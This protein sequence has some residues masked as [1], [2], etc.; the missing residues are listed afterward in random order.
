MSEYAAEVIIIAILAV[1]VVIYLVLRHRENMKRMELGYMPNA[2]FAP[3][4]ETPLVPAPKNPVW[5]KRH[6][7]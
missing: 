5:E 7:G 1:V 2:P 3:W 4:N 6:S